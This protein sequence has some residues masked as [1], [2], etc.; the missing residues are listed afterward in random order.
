[1]SNT[2]SD[3]NLSGHHR[4]EAADVSI[5]NGLGLLKWKGVVFTPEEECPSSEHHSSDEH[6][7]YTDETDHG[8]SPQNDIVTINLNRGWNSRLGFSL[9][10][11]E[12]GQT[13][14]TTIYADSVAAKDGRL[15]M[16]DRVVRVNGINCEEMST[17]EIID[18][19]R[20]TRGNI[21]LGVLQQ[22]Y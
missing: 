8:T 16:G 1:L 2:N 14:I 12:N 10:P 20:K 15:Q 17:E 5:G 7:E 11:Q 22:P 18:I 13:I 6:S 3:H 4:V 19:L 9:Q 21:A